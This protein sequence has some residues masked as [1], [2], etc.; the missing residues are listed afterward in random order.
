MEVMCRTSGGCAKAWGEGVLLPSG[1][2]G[3][4]T[5]LSIH[6]FSL[7]LSG[8][9]SVF[10]CYI[11]FLFWVSDDFWFLQLEASTNQELNQQIPL[12]NL[13]SKILCRVVHIHLLVLCFRS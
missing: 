3:T 9:K 11:C 7:F 10:S 2:Y 6:L 12:F 1:S 13:P 5:I 4:S 8:S